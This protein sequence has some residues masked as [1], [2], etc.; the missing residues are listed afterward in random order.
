MSRASGILRYLAECYRENGS[1]IGI[2]SL[3]S[4]RVRQSLIVEGEDAVVSRTVLDGL[5][6]VPGKKAATLATQAKLYEKECELFY[7]SL[8][9]IAPLEREEG[10]TSLSFAPLILYPTVV[11]S[12]SETSG[13]EFSIDTS[14]RLLN[15]ALLE[16]FGNDDFISGIEKAIDA[17]CHTEG[18]IGEVRRLFEENFPDAAAGG[19]FKFPY[20]L[21]DS[22]LKEVFELVGKEVKCPVTLL[23]A[24][25]LFLADR[26][27]EMRGVLNDLAAIAVSAMATAPYELS[28]P[29]R[30]I[31]GEAAIG[32][33]SVRKRGEIP[34]ILSV[35]QEQVAASARS[36]PLTLAV[37]PPGT[38]K[39]FTIAALAMEAM[40]RGESVLIASKMDHA[41]DVVADKIEETLGLPG[42]CVR[43]GRKSYLKDLKRFLEDLL[44]GLLTGEELGRAVIQQ[45]GKELS[46]GKGTI[47]RAERE[48]EKR[49]AREEKRGQLLNAAAP[50]FFTR[51]RIARL[52]TRA[53]AEPNLNTLAGDFSGRLGQQIADTVAFLKLKRRHL[54]QEALRRH[55]KTF[56]AFSK[57]VRARTS[58]RQESYFEEVRWDALLTA[59][60]VW[61]VNLS[62]LHRIIPLDSG[63][64]DLVI[65]D[66][67]SQCDIASALPAL[68][69]AK[70]AVITGDPKQLRHLSF[71]QTAR[72]DEFATRFGLN[73]E[74]KERFHFRNVSLVDLVATGIRDQASVIFL[75]EHFRSR[76]AIIGF[77]NREFYAGQLAI[78]TGHRDA[79][80][81]FE[82]PLS[83][84][85]TGGRRGANGVNEDEVTAILAQLAELTRSGAPALSIGILSPFRAQVDAILARVEKSV[86]LTRLLDQHDLL[87]GTAHSFQGEER[88]IMLLSFALDGDSPSASFR[89]LE[90]ED[91]FN[92]SIT[93]ARRENQIFI[94]FDPA[95]APHGLASRFLAYARQAGAEGG[96]GL[97]RVESGTQPSLV[98]LRSALEERGFEVA[99]N[100]PLGSF[101]IDLLC[102]GH[103]K[104]LAIDLIGFPGPHAAAVSL[105][106]HLMMARAG[107]QLFPVTMLEWQS[108]RDQVLRELDGW[109][110][111]EHG[112][113]RVPDES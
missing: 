28:D 107:I 100:F 11:E 81:G 6:Y 7:G 24:A 102:R 12:V 97:K 32:A 23:S 109:I 58:Q 50:G 49:C 16:T 92:V 27:T 110:A 113:S 95:R 105:E 61:L 76:P 25:A 17:E 69:R 39:S 106:R 111:R 103:G 22:E 21:T 88:D 42:V 82:P 98:E 90:K 3:S 40:S 104:S 35:A 94:S 86:D 15:F 34:A 44:S 93:R 2:T 55:R 91:V 19:L 33:T 83:V 74:E 31:L 70:R 13:A 78:M 26:S 60:P 112:P 45:A 18:C 101:E 65:I 36:H 8:F 38:G 63:L 108:K 10:K 9:V 89:F 37:G 41:V 75:N 99:E 48:F 87:V 62:D 96:R 77:S 4:G 59:L 72:Q 5:L 56:Q 73:D 47:E 67:A 85:E 51:W 79:D 66:E 29:V 57:G 20:L 84:H 30:V 71:L 53:A 14:R 54:L 52:K 64:F 46:R 68:Q 1:R 43:A 80:L